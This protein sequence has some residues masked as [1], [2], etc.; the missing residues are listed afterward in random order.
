MQKKKKGSN[1]KKFWY[2]AG[3]TLVNNNWEKIH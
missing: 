3:M 1:F 2:P